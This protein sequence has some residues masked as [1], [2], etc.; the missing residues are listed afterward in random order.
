M[1]RHAGEAARGGVQQG[2]FKAGSLPRSPAP[3]GRDSIC[4]L[5]ANLSALNLHATHAAAPTQPPAGPA[6]PPSAPPYGGVAERQGALVEP[7]GHSQQAPGPGSHLQWEGVKKRGVLQKERR[8]ARTTRGSQAA[9]GFETPEDGDL[10]RYEGHRIAMR[11]ICRV[12]ERDMRRKQ[13]VWALPSFAFAPEPQEGER[14][15]SAAKQLCPPPLR[16]RTPL[17]TSQT[18][19]ASCRP[20]TARATKSRPPQPLRQ[21]QQRQVRRCGSK[22]PTVVSVYALPGMP[23]AA[24]LAP[25]P[26]PMSQDP[27]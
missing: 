14:G 25:C 13:K 1:H 16:T 20:S 27:R 24:P 10:D 26:A 15:P 21:R 8:L 19:L 9:T 11:T 22:P 23:P 4:R 5:P 7:P 18:I 12:G 17:T 2:R 3:R 6:C